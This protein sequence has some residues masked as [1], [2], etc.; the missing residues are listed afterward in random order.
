M[1]ASNQG[2]R[3]EPVLDFGMLPKHFRNV[4][5]FADEE[6]LRLHCI[7]A[8]TIAVEKNDERLAWLN[9][10]A[11]RTIGESISGEIIEGERV[12]ALLFC[13]LV[14]WMAHEEGVFR[15]PFGLQFAEH[16]ANISLVLNSPWIRETQE[17]CE[18]RQTPALPIQHYRILSL[19]TI[20]D[21]VASAPDFEWI[22]NKDSIRNLT[23][24]F[25]DS[26]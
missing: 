18:F 19:T 23:S 24:E 5:A 22:N 15:L 1:N 21:V 14:G 20:I 11:R 25:M 4:R 17:F 9:P 10:K 6:Y 2:P 8:Q 26:D 12:L 16:P 7:E 3:L 13:N